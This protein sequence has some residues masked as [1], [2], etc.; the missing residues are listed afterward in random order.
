MRPGRRARQRSPPSP[1]PPEAAAR[2]PHSP[3]RSGTTVRPRRHDRLGGPTGMTA[4]VSLR[5]PYLIFDRLLNG[6]TLLGYASASKDAEELSSCHHR[7][8]LAL[9]VPAARLRPA[10]RVGPRGLRPDRPGSWL[11]TRQTPSSR[12]GRCARAV[13]PPSRSPGRSTSGQRTQ[14]H[15]HDAGHQR[16]QQEQRDFDPRVQQPDLPVDVSGLDA[17]GFGWHER[18]LMND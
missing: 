13:I 11:P 17:V 18:L 8:A 15:E 14:V 7:A 2:R 9:A 12:S 16:Q 3:R 5:L 4:N 10:C 6:P 1:I